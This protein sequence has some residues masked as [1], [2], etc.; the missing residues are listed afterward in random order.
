MEYKIERLGD[1]E[2]L[3]NI[4]IPKEVIDQKVA[5]KLKSYQRTAKLPGFRKGKAP[6]DIIYRKYYDIAL[7]EVITELIESTSRD[8]IAKENLKLL[9]RG[10]LLESKWQ[11]TTL[12]STIKLEVFP[13][14]EFGDY[15]ELEVRIPDFKLKD[16]E[17]TAILE[18]LCQLHPRYTPHTHITEDTVQT[19]SFTINLRWRG[20]WR[21]F[22]VDDFMFFIDEKFFPNPINTELLNKKVGTTL[23]LKHEYPL[24]YEDPDLKG[25]QVE[26]KF[27]IENVESPSPATVRELASTVGFKSDQSLRKALRSILQQYRDTKRHTVL[28]YKLLETLRQTYVFEPPPRIVEAY[29]K[30]FLEHYRKEHD[31]LDPNLRTTIK[32]LAH[33][34]AQEDIL[35]QLIAAKEGLHG[36]ELTQKVVDFLLDK[37][38]II[39]ETKHKGGNKDATR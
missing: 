31:V 28:K 25:E 32:K 21:T 22:R 29:E 34:Q 19:V 30:A 13:Q 10:E 35:I 24:D 23:E 33:M 12:V 9:T 2:L 36:K 11:D 39:E 3:L 4:H 37:V 8:I 18:R 1:C 16:D 15:S 14:I 17:L 38:K 27:R 5:S 6:M 7:Q 20:L 26:Y